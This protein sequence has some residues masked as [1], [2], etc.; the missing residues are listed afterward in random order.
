MCHCSVH[1]CN[2]DPVTYTDVPVF[3]ILDVYGMLFF[4]PSFGAFDYYDDPIPPGTTTIQVLPSFPWPAGAGEAHDIHFYAAM[5]N[6]AM[7]DLMG[8]MDMFAFGWR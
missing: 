2:T 5:T 3:V 8:D 1:V 7:T 6:P 4:A